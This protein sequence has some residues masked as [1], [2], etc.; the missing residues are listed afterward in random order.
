MPEVPVSSRGRPAWRVRACLAMW[1][2]ALLGLAP[3]AQPALPV[4]IAAVPASSEESLASPD[5]ARDAS[6]P[7]AGARPAQPLGQGVL[8]RAW[9]AETAFGPP[10]AKPPLLR[11][12]AAA[13][14]LVAASATVT[15]TD[16]A[17]EV[18]HRSS[19]GSARAPTGP[20]A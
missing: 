20:P 3:V 5:G 19:V 17:S 1:F 6:A 13:A 11:P 2:A 10:P 15:M 12:T 4:D 16:V 18:F 14:P 8:A 9:L 7:A